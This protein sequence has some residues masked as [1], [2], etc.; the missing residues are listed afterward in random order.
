MLAKCF[1]MYS[2][3]YIF[4]LNMCKPTFLEMGLGKQQVS[5]SVPYMKR[6]AP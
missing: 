2:Y 4:S 5:K 1:C 3:V 6:Y